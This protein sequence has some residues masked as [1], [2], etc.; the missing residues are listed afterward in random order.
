MMYMKL[1]QIS[2]VLAQNYVVQVLYKYHQVPICAY[3]PE[4][5][6]YFGIIF[7]NQMAVGYIC[8]AS[9]KSRITKLLPL[10][11]SDL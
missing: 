2:T 7:P 10:N 9:F 4:R 3:Y 6:H 11:S 1:T 8:S 5:E